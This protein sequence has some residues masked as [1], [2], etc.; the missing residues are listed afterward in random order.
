MNSKDLQSL[1]LQDLH[2]LGEWTAAEMQMTKSGSQIDLTECIKVEK[3]FIRRG[4]LKL[5]QQIW[6][7]NE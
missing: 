2:S 4:L 5:W 7:R 1:T 3:E 6:N